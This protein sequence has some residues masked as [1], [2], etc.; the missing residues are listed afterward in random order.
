MNTKEFF[1]EMKLDEDKMMYSDHV[2]YALLEVKDQC[3]DI[4]DVILLS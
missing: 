1:K 2:K 4:L 3:I